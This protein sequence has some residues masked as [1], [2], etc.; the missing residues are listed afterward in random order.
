MLRLFARA[1]VRA[2]LPVR[3]SHGFNPRPQISLPL[4]RPV[5]IASEAERVVFGFTRDVVASDIVV[6]LSRQ[7]PAGIILHGAEPLGPKQHC[8]PHRVHY[9]VALSGLDRTL[10]QA[11]R[12]RVIDSDTVVYDRFV[13]N[14]SRYR[15]V[16]L[17]PYIESIE[18]TSD[19]VFFS[20]CVTPDGSAKP[21]EICDLLGIGTENVNHLI[22]RLSVEWQ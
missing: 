2:D 3:Y 20:L 5:G 17:R 18:V 22:C 9:R 12:D 19:A 4:P 14:V 11:A 8:V 1:A 10:L 15:R 21:S 13:H 16:D 7:I 6:R